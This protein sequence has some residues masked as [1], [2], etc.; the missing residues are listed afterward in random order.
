MGKSITDKINKSLK[1]GDPV[2][3]GGYIIYP[4]VTSGETEPNKAAIY[5]GSDLIYR[6]SSIEEAIEWVSSKETHNKRISGLMSFRA[7]LRIKGRHLGI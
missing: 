5:L 6:A 4:I 7:F 2:S 1:G 3:L